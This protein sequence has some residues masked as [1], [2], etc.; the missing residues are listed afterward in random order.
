MKKLTIALSL[1]IIGFISYGQLNPVKN[2]NLWESYQLSNYDC[3]QFNCFYL[4]WL[5]PDTSSTDTLIG[6]NIYH[7]GSLYLNLTSTEYGCPGWPTSGC[8]MT[9]PNWYGDGS[10]FWITVKALYNYDSSASIATDSFYVAGVMI[11]INKYNSKKYFT[12]FPNPFTNHTILNISNEIS[13]ATLTIYTPQGKQ[14]KQIKN[15]S[16][17][18]ITLERN[19]LPNGLYF[20]IL[21][22]GEK[23]IATE[24]LIIT[25]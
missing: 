17:Q 21:T 14:V 3:P 4:S 16:S 18:S 12:I 13:N 22:Q 10:P 9:S 8:S 7:D 23:I 1:Y 5:P 20:T 11:G 25:D 15:I 24:K 19:H 2:L 6:Y